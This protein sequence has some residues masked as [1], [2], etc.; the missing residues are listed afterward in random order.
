MAVEY[1]LLTWAGLGTTVTFTDAGDV[2]NFTAHGAPNG[3]AFRFT[4]TGA[5]PTGLTA[6]TT[7]YLRQGADANKFL[8]YPTQADAI[9]GTNQVTFSGAGSG[10]NKVVGEYWS[11][12]G[13]EARA[14]YGT[15]GSERVYPRL[16][17]CLSYYN[18]Y[19]NK[20]LDK[21]VVIEVQG[22]WTD[23]TGNT[24][25]MERFKS[26]TL[27]SKIN[28]V[29]DAAAFHGGLVGG[30]YALVVNTNTYAVY[31]SQPD[32]IVDGLELRCTYA[33]PTYAVV[34]AST[35]SVGLR[36]SNCILQGQR[37]VNVYAAYTHIFNNIFLNC[38]DSGV[39]DYGNPMG[40]VV[41][42]NIAY[43]CAVGF[44]GYTTTTNPLMTTYIGNIALN[45]T[46]NWS[47]LNQTA[48][49]A[50][51]L[52]ALYNMGDS[53][54]VKTITFENGSGTLTCR[55]TG[56]GFTVAT[57]VFFK[58]GGGAT[59]PTGVSFDAIY[60]IKTVTADTFTL[61]TTPP[62]AAI[63]YIDSGS[64]TMTLSLVFDTTAT[65]GVVSASDFTNAT[66]YDF[67]PAL[68]SSPQI[69][70]VPPLDYDL[71]G[72]AV[73]DAVRPNYEA[74]TFPNN[75]SDAGPFEFD[76]G[77]G[78]APSTVTI[79]IT[80]MA[81]GSEIAIYKASDMSVILAPQSTSGSYSGTYT[82]TGD[83]NII[84][85][86]RK[87]TSVT[88]YLPYEYA[89]TITS[90]GFQLVVSQIPDTIAQ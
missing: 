60:Y 86:V 72:Y 20:G 21:D 10:T 59:P 3:H 54:D 47:L 6:G 63:T 34:Y 82:Y 44:K 66:S 58:S 46:L 78:L 49:A 17:D 26:F 23:S 1:S 83:T 39:Y 16:Y 27:W 67:T 76:H 36:V 64:G 8:V 9:A 32:C 35:K 50:C 4:T 85:R 80:G 42:Y 11:A 61:T 75:H 33:T 19:A 89:G 55:L 65:A 43:G 53:S 52:V 22:K 15:A 70:F 90:T 51:R 77:E 68:S 31:P 41:A 12:L 48:Y 71:P 88:R 79:S 24:F 81:S 14:R 30:G 40:C 13:T 28:G 73:N 18:T 29:R 25:T 45:N 57:P 87:G 84:V 5:L 7:Y 69:N 62:G 56:H 38:T 74:A 2:V 37:G